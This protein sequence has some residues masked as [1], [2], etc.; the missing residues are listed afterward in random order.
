MRGA[1]SSS[2]LEDMNMGNNWWKKRNSPR[3]SPIKMATQDHWSSLQTRV[4]SLVSWD[5]G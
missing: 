4:H 3:W 5:P 2:Q 1:A